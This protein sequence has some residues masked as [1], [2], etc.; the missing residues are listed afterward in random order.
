[1]QAALIDEIK[2]ILHA[3][4][5]DRLLNHDYGVSPVDFFSR[6]PFASVNAQYQNGL[7]PFASSTNDAI[8]RT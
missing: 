2:T 3:S 7:R 5:I 4:R 6:R 8:F 1:M